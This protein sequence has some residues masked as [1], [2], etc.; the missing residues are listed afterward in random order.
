MT[1]FAKQNMTEQIGRT[2]PNKIAVGNASF[3][4]SAERKYVENFG[5]PYLAILGVKPS[6][7]VNNLSCAIGIE[8]ST[9]ERLRKESENIQNMVK[10]GIPIHDLISKWEDN[11]KKI[12][13]V[14]DHSDCLMLLMIAL[15]QVVESEKRLRDI[16]SKDLNSPL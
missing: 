3:V 6:I 14:M 10:G 1:L 11:A 15:N 4:P 2:S 9:V 13:T 16:F 8:R 5:A 7:I 12:K